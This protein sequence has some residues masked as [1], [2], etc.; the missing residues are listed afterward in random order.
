MIISDVWGRPGLADGNTGVFFALENQSAVD[1][2]LIS[3]DSSTADAVEIHQ[4]MMEDGVMKMVPQEHVLVSAGEHVVFKPGDLH[5]MLIGLKQ[6][7][8]I[9][10]EFEVTLVFENAGN[11]TILVKVQE[12]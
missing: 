8:E 2:M 9:G 1:D 12:P 11:I 5:V 10:D 7:I 4:T 6:T 3:A